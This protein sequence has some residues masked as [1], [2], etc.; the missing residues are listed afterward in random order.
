MGRKG[1]KTR[2]IYIKLYISI[3]SRQNFPHPPKV[4]L[5]ETLYVELPKNLVI[6]FKGTLAS[7][8]LD[9]TKTPHSCLLLLNSEQR[10]SP[11]LLKLPI[12]GGHLKPPKA[13]CGRPKPSAQGHLRSPWAGHRCSGPPAVGRGLPW[14]GCGW[15]GAIHV[16]FGA[17]TAIRAVFEAGC[18]FRVGQ[19]TAAGVQFLFFRRFLQ[20]I[21][22]TK[23][24]AI[25]L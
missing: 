15:S 18:D 10:I 25:I 2:R 8:L 9:T 11:Q 16:H 13:I 1:V 14:A 17:A 20:R 21:F 23:H 4:F 24:W 19:R 3:F 12:A 7:L 6:C 22:A 5:S